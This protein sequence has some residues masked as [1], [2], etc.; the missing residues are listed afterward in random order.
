MDQETLI[1]ER[2]G[3]HFRCHAKSLRYQMKGSGE[4][5]KSFVQRGNIHLH[6]LSTNFTEDKYS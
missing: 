6:F 5:V 4:P 2:L 1:M 3:R